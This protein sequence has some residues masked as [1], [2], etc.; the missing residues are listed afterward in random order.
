MHFAPVTP[1]LHPYAPAR[2]APA[3]AAPPVHAPG[4]RRPLRARGAWEEVRPTQVGGGKKFGEG[5]EMGEENALVPGSPRPQP[6][7]AQRQQLYRPCKD[8]HQLRLC[9]PCTMPVLPTHSKLVRY[10]SRSVHLG[11]WQKNT[12][13]AMW[14]LSHI[15]IAPRYSHVVLLPILA[16][17]LV[18][19]ILVVHF[20]G[21]AEHG[22]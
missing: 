12:S 18:H 1:Q 16:R 9:E 19:A 13:V 4:G 6:A 17:P 11:P 20:G 5:R 10:V 2:A 14:T 8:T 3:R 7:H 21:P 15:P 22:G